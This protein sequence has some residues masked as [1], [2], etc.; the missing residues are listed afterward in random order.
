MSLILKNVLSV[1]IQEIVD[2]C[3]KNDRQAQ[4]VLY[5]WLAPKLLGLCVR[6]FKD[7]SEAED[8]MQDALV[9]IFMNLDKYRDDHYFEAWCK[10]IALNCALNQLKVNNRMKFDRDLKK[11]ENTEFTEAEVSSVNPEQIISCLDG[12]PEGYRTI[13]NL[14]LI[15]GFSH[16]DIADKLGIS[17]STS[18]SQYSRARHQL[19]KL[20]KEKMNSSESKLA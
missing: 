13:V 11:I 18:R 14:F 10:R 12:L 20:L 4:V 6:Y 17:E 16:K 9:K 2:K 3:K 19:S 7:R 1:N 5:N 8:T 15:D